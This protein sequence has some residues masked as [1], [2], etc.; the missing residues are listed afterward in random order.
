MGDFAEGISQL[1]TVILRNICDYVELRAD[2]VGGVQAAAESHFDNG[3]V[4]IFPDEPLEG[5][6][7]CEFKE[8]RLQAEIHC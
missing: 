2:N 6:Y 8:R 1:C 7:G 4:N 5:H 3:Y